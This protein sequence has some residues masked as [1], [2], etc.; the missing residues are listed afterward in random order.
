MAGGAF[1]AGHDKGNFLLDPLAARLAETALQIRDD[2]FELVKVGA[3]AKHALALHLNTLVTRAVQQGV[4]GLLA[5][6]LNGGIECKAVALA[7]RL[8]GHFRDG[9]L[10]VIPAAGLDGTFPD[11][12]A[13][14]G[15]DTRRVDLHEGA[16]TCTLLAGTEGI[17]EAEHPW[18]QLLDGDA[19][20]GAGVALAEHH[21][22]TANDVDDDK[23]VCLRQRGFYGIGQTPAD[24][25]VDDQTVH[26][27]L[28]GVLDVLF[29]VDLLAQIVHIAVDAHAGKT[30]SAG[31]IQLLGLGALAGTHN[32]GHGSELA[33]NLKTHLLRYP[34]D[35]L[36]H[37]K[38]EKVEILGKQKL[39]TT[40][41]GEKFL[42]PALIIATGASW[43]RLNVPG[44]AEYIG[45][46]VAF[47]PHCDGPFYKGKHVAVV[48]GG[49]SGIEAAIDLAGICSKVTV[50]E[51]MDEL[52]ADNVLQERL[53]TLPNVEVFV[54]SQ[55][56]KVVGNGDKLTALRIKD[57]KTEEERLVELDGVFVQIGLSANSSAFREVVETNRPGEI[58][59]DAH[60]RTNVTG[61]YAAGDVSTVPYKQIIISMGEGAKAALSAF[62]D[63]VRGV[64]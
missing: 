8:I 13:L 52:K 41:V 34:V 1:L 48:G 40:S 7:Q 15:D 32:G 38:I 35:L 14:V 37:R 26:D 36:E 58:V 12:L 5:E 43:R 56:T 10:G 19:V 29:E 57:R 54:S 20:L 2:A 9:A 44:E 59:I 18:G 4:Q 64:I 3:G 55:T 60:C 39:V 30:S 42:A 53:K 31:G 16:E 25:V 24:R 22:F 45:R 6:V 61:I 33:D 28:N 47:C 51:F 50:F 23:P 63:R 27:D 17:V 62:D 21:R 46:G 11:G 49:N